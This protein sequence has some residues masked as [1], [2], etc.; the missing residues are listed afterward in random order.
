M[1]RYIEQL[2]ECTDP[3]DADWV[4]I[5]DN[6]AGATD[7]DRRLSLSRIAKLG[8][9]N[10]LP[11]VY[12][13]GTTLTIS[14][15]TITVTGSYHLVDTEGAAATDDLTTIE[16]GV[17]GQILYLRTAN[18]GRDVTLKSGA[19]LLL[20]SDVL[21]NGSGDVVQLIRINSTTWAKVSHS[22]N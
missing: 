2:N 14:S 1:A 21:L 12:G 17:A 7:K 22:D 10:S 11:L 18:S 3:A 4:W 6:S 15:G 5:V 20:G 9:A 16:G 8:V 13:P 19:G